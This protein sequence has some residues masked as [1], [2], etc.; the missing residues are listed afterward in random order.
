MNR[1]TF[2]SAPVLAA[3][4]TSASAATPPPQVQATG[5]G[6]A[7]TPAEYAALL[8]K[9]SGSIEPDSYSLGGVVAKLEQTVAAALGKETAVWLSTGTLANHLAVRLLAGDRRRLLVQQESHL[10]NDCGDCCQILSGLNMVPLA[11]GKAT[12]TVEDLDSAAGRG[13]SGRVAVPIGAIQI[14]SPVRRKRGEVFDF[15]EM[16][17][18]SHWARERGIGL[19][20]D[21]ARLYLASGYSGIPVREY[22]GLFDTVYVSMYKY[23]NAASGAVLA[24]PKKLLDNL[25]HPRRMFGNGL[26]AV[27]PFAAVALHYFEGFPERYTRAVTTSERVISA[28]KAD[29]RFEVTRVANGTNIFELHAKGVDADALRKRAHAAGLVLG[30]P[31]DGRFSVQVNETWGRVSAEEI[32]A[33]LG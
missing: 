16:K 21:G 12:F 24:G 13:A 3:A 20:L 10:Y 33:R 5:D 7:H 17:R 4:A 19:H 2:F 26:N 22:A 32:L 6:I 18:V 11:P 9:I 1:R 8:H 29:A 28:L 15:A 25:F 27:W 30:I 31:K 23:F 14:E